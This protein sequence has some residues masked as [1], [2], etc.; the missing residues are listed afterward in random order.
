MPEQPLATVCIAC[1]NAGALVEQAIESIQAQ[2]YPHLELLLIDDGS[3]DVSKH[4]LD[5]YATAPHTRLIRLAQNK[6]LRHARQLAIEAATGTYLFY[7]DADD[8]SHPTRIARQ[9]ALLEAQPEVV[10][11]GTGVNLINEAGEKTGA[12]WAEINHLKMES[13]LFLKMPMASPTM[14]FRLQ[15]LRQPH[16]QVPAQVVQAEDYVLLAKLLP[17]GKM[18]NVAEPLYNYREHAHTHRITHDKNNADIVQ[19]RMMAWRTLLQYLQLEA[20]DAVLEVHDKTI[21]YRSKIEE[22]H[23]AS[24]PAYLQL[25]GHMKRANRKLAVFNGPLF[26]GDMEYKMYN[27]LLHPAISMQQA[28]AWG[29]QHRAALGYANWFK[30]CLNRLRRSIGQ[31]E[32]PHADVSNRA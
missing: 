13:A 15:A 5:R 2:T 1:F 6:G 19:G 27:T 28:M 4:I 17:L 11:C 10:V 3:E 22:K 18:A 20:S 24:F 25:L 9:V 30:L 7:Q 26:D 29:W 32:Q 8:V 23:L 16:T 21:F 31:K 14:G 12:K